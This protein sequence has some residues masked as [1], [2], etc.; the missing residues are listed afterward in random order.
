MAHLLGGAAAA[1]APRHSSRAGAA[2]PRGN[3][4]ISQN[5]GAVSG[6]P[7]VGNRNAANL[8]LHDDL[9]VLP[10]LERR[11]DVLHRDAPDDRHRPDRDPSAAAREA[12]TRSD[13]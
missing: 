1:P 10:D 5:L 3:G 13:V 9:A 6:W 4:G 2:L 12:L 7:G 8:H 11:R